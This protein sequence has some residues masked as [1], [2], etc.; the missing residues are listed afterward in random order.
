MLLIGMTLLPCKHILTTKIELFCT[1][2]KNNK[3]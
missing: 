3:L 2:N 1:Y